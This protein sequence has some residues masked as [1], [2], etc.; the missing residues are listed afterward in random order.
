[1]SKLPYIIA[2]DFDGTLVSD[3]FPEIGEK[4]EQVFTIVKLAQNIGAKIV[5]WTCRHNTALMQAVDYC[6]SQGLKFD[7][8]NSNIA[9]VQELYGHDTRKVFADVYIDDKSVLPTA[10]NLLEVLEVAI[11]KKYT[12]ADIKMDK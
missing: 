7:A 5:L 2:V 9:E 8:V 6:R 11:R 12:I 4:N 10:S 3:K 1:M